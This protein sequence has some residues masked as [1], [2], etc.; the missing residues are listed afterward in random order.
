MTHLVEVQSSRG[1]LGNRNLR[2]RR[3]GL[4]HFGLLGWDGRG[5]LVSEVREGARRFLLTTCWARDLD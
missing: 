4:A 2:R 5:K 1:R 3:V